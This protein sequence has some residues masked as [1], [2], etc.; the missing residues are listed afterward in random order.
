MRSTTIPVYVLCD[1]ESVMTFP[2]LRCRYLCTKSTSQSHNSA[3]TRKLTN[4]ILP[5]IKSVHR[6]TLTVI[7]AEAISEENNRT[8]A[9]SATT[10]KRTARMT[11][12]EQRTK[13]FF[14]R[15]LIT[16]GSQ[17]EKDGYDGHPPISVPYGPNPPYK[18]CV[19]N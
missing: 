2:I 11:N 12:Y 13:R 8:F 16:G 9:M 5:A 19:S 3:I 10:V 1:G 7:R 18:D 4:Q 6:P 15:K 17:R 14:R